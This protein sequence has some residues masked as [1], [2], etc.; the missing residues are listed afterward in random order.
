MIE[1]VR[2]R[3]GVSN[4]IGP[5]FSYADALFEVA[6]AQGNVG[7]STGITGPSMHPIAEG[8]LVINMWI[9]RLEIIPVLVFAR[10]LIHGINP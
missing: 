10:S 4:L 6:N 3:G 7:L 5:E 8:M 1:T 2:E 9:S